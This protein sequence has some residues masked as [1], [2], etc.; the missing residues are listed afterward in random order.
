MIRSQFYERESRKFV[1][2]LKEAGNV[3]SRVKN[4][5]ERGPYPGGV[6][7][8]AEK[9]LDDLEDDV[10][11][12]LRKAV[13]DFSHQ[14]SVQRVN[15]LLAVS[16]KADTV[17]LEIGEDSL[18]GLAWDMALEMMAKLAEDA[19]KEFRKLPSSDH[20]AKWFGMRINCDVLGVDQRS[21]CPVFTFKGRKPYT[22][23]TGDTLSK[24][25]Q[26]FYGNANLWDIIYE[27]N[28]MDH[29]P[30]RISPGQKFLI[31]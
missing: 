13:F 26:R 28:R 17:G 25:A 22:V 23:E 9:L 7:G 12:E 3:P 20:Y 21:H 4:K 15:E 11:A 14:P 19:E 10:Q 30:D 16:V 24:L 8:Y 29:H 6:Y 1:P 5:K 18:A 2:P 27:Q 31:P